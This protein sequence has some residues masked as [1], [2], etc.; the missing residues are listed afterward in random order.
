[1]KVTYEII[2]NTN[3]SLTRPLQLLKAETSI[4]KKV[5]DICLP[6]DE[7]FLDTKHSKRTTRPLRS[8]FG[9]TFTPFLGH[10]VWRKLHL[11]VVIRRA[12]VLI[13]HGSAGRPHGGL[14]GRR[15]NV[16][17]LPGSCGPLLLSSGH[18]VSTSTVEIMDLNASHQQVMIVTDDT[19][20]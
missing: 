1:M 12:G 15:L 10:S 20:E 6:D 13:L 3:P 8:D 14:L 19:G 5:T 17:V 11:V 18:A 4:P 7:T 2:Q 9:R 16:R